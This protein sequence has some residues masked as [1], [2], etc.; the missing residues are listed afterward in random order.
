MQENVELFRVLRNDRKKQK[1]EA[2]SDDITD[3]LITKAAN[4]LTYIDIL[5]AF[6][7]SI[8]G[9]LHT[10]FVCK[11]SNNLDVS[12]HGNIDQSIPGMDCWNV[13]LLTLLFQPPQQTTTTLPAY[14]GLTWTDWR[15]YSDT[16]FNHFPGRCYI[17][18]N[19]VAHNVTFCFRKLPMAAP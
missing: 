10:S 19:Q 6:A 7:K 8:A 14:Y 15:L 4:V 12:P 16:Y 2:G 11:M 1:V 18:Q 9:C 13:L 5:Q 17:E 3:R